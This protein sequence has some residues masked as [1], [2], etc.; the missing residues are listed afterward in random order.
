MSALYDRCVEAYEF[1]NQESQVNQ[2]G[3]RLFTGSITKIV[4]RTGVSSKYYS[5]VRQLLLSPHTDPCIE[6]VQRGNSEQPSVIL[7]HHPPPPEWA[8]IT[9]GD[10]TTDAVSA[11]MVAELESRLSR[12]ETWR[13]SIGEV[14]LSKV[15]QD[16]E[17][18]LSKLERG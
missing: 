17:R 5:Q 1:M 2:H 12:V 3:E 4:R 8:G 11:T 6:I 7:L 16:F 13:E 10:L 15:L 9:A 18:R 14:N